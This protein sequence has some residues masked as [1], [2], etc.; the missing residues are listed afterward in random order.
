MIYLASD[1]MGYKV[2]SLASESDIGQINGILIDPY[3]FTIAGFWL[4]TF[5]KGYQAYP[6]LLTQSLRQIDRRRIFINDTN[7]LNE[8]EDLPKLNEVLNIDYQM[9]GK[10]IVSTTKNYL[11]RIEDFSFDDYNFDVVYLVVKPPLYHRLTQSRL[12]FSRGQIE[13]VSNKEIE[14]NVS[15]QTESFQSAPTN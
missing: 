8:P 4:E 10:R 13:K 7:E 2:I 15:P 1:F 9:I 5:M 6:I 3:K 14:V 12:Q 11:G